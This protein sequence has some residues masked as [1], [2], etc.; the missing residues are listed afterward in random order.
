MISK[1]KDGPYISNVGGVANEVYSDETSST[2]RG[3]PVNI[4]IGQ[5]RQPVYMLIW[6]QKGGSGTAPFW[7][8]GRTYGDSRCSRAE[9]PCILGF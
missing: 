8:G 7:G 4:F 5:H 2:F 1:I 6:S 3:N 9:D